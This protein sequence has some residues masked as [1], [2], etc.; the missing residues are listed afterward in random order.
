MEHAKRLYLVDEFDRQYK[1]LQRPPAAVAKTRSAIQLSDTLRDKNLDDHEKVRRYLAELHRYLSIK[2]P[3]QQQQQ[4]QRKRARTD[5]SHPFNTDTP[6]QQDPGVATGVTTRQQLELQKRAERANAATAVAATDKQQ[7]GTDD[8]GEYGGI[9]DLFATTTA[10][11]DDDGG[12]FVF[13][14]APPESSAATTK[15][16]TGIKRKKVTQAYDFGGFSRDWS[17]LV[18]RKNN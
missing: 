12:V 2:V 18:A 3:Q 15:T 8:V 10:G 11:G 17:R 13:G 14:A 1:Q 4:Q 7:P 5:T 9:A 6:H 16:K